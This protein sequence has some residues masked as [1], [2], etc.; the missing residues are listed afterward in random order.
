MGMV[1]VK[2]LVI[3]RKR[4]KEYLYWQP[5]EKYWVQGQWK[6]CP[7]NRVRVKSLDEARDYN[8]ALEKWR[9]GKEAVRPAGQPGTFDWLVT[10]Y[11]KDSSFTRLS[12]RTRGV[13][14][15]ALAIA[16]KIIGDLPAAEVSRADA[17]A[18]YQANKP[19]SRRAAMI[20]QTARVVYNFGIDAG[21]LTS[22]PF[23][24]Q[25]VAAAK[26]R[27]TIWPL[28]LHE[29]AKAQAISEGAHSVALALQLGLDIGQRPAD[30]RALA[31]NAYNGHSIRLTQQ[32]TGAAVNVPVM[33]S[34]RAALE[35]TPRISPL[36]LI[37]EITGKPYTKDMLSRR[38]REVCQRAGIPDEYQFRDL[39]RT[40]VVRLAEHGCEIPEICAITGHKLSEATQ[41]L[42]VYCPRTSRMAENAVAKLEKRK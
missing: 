41:I 33:Q 36:M 32:K 26:P 25:R 14:D 8:A 5:K 24:K 35:T 9:M 11:K 16:S 34:L 22:N 29:A 31:W 15:Y 42:E 13:Y 19:G 23:E 7:F 27:Q 18:I 28:D 39:R 1:K 10:Q 38:I 40:A 17:K 30:L 12:E 6:K 2:Y 37:E 4:G 21:H 20:M 3:K